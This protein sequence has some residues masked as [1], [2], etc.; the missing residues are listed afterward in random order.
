VSGLIGRAGEF[1]VAG[2]LL[3]SGLDVAFPALD[4]GID[5]FAYRQTAPATVVP[6]QVKTWS[7]AG[8]AFERVWFSIPGIVLVQVICVTST[9]EFYVFRGLNDVETALVVQTV[10]SDSWKVGGKYSSPVPVGVERM[11]RMQ[12]FRDAW[13]GIASLLPS[14]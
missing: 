13:A 5:M 10:Q 1:L 7:Q 3:R 14:P 4:T 6:I 12:A 2:E 11:A 8:Y 9:P